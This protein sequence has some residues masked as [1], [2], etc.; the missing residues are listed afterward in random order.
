ME[1]DYRRRREEMVERQIAARGISDKRVLA[2]MRKVERHLFVPDAL[3][4]QAYRDFPLPIGEGQTISQP[5]IV[6]EMTQALALSP[7]DKVLEIGTG[8]GYQTAILAELAEKV[9]T[10]ERLRALFISARK[11]F[12]TLRLANVVAKCSDGTLGWPEEAP[13]DAILVTAGAPAIPKILL[14]QLGL[15]G[16][17]V[18]PAGGED[19]QNL[20]KMVRGQEGIRQINMGGCRFVKLIGKEGWGG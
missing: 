1:T 12:D 17:M 5:F 20:I 3:R 11:I 8:S 10:I 6:A 19:T 9:Y 18:L 2:A 16:R 7:T 14:S 4:D 15:G 13:F